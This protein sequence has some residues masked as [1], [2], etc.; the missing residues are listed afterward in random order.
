VWLLLVVAA[1]V[2]IFVIMMVLETL[3]FAVD[4]IFIFYLL[5]SESAKF[6]D[7]YVPFCSPDLQV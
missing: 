4:S 2:S 1:Y 3:N 5:D 7:D 6:S